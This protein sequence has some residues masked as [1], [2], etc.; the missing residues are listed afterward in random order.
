MAAL[1]ATLWWYRA[2]HRAMLHRLRRLGLPAGTR[3]L[4][5][6]CGTGG[7]LRQ[8]AEAFPDWRSE[9]VEFDPEAAEW[10][11]R[12]SALPVAVGS[13]NGLG[14]ADASFDVIISN[15]V[16]GHA[17]V[18]GAK[19]LAEFFRCLKPG[20]R[21]LMNLPAYEWMKS[22]HDLHVHNAR[23]FTAGRIGLALQAAGFRPQHLGY[24][25]SLLFPVMVLHRMVQARN[26]E[27]SDVKPFPPLLDALFFRVVDCERHLEDLGLNLPFG[28]SVVVLAERPA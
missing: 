8:I 28:G 3:L 23:R 20:G 26:A 5:A 4:D 9:G 14:Y 6:G 18:D 16:L 22:A 19:A 11:A 27:A 10:A 7:L 25:N 15:D 13:V 1:E 17:G 12:K 24:W 2:L 21:L